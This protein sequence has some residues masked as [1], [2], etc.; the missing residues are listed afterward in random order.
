MNTFNSNDLERISQIN[1]NNRRKYEKRLI[2]KACNKIG[3]MLIICTVVMNV[4]AIPLSTILVF[5]GNFDITGETGVSGIPYSLYYLL[6]GILEF[7]GF[8]LVPVIFCLIFKFKLSEALPIRGEGKYNIL[9]LILGGYAICTLS[10]Y[11]VSILNS[12]LSMFGLENTTGI[13]TEAKTPK[14]QIIYFICIAIIPAITEEIAFRG[15]VL[16][17]LRPYDDGFAVLVSAIL[18]GLVHGNFVQIPF[19]FIV[20]LVCAVLVVKTNSI[21]PSI[22]LHLLNNGTSVLLDCI[23]E[24]TSRGTYEILSTIIVMVLTIIG[25]VAIIL[26]CKKGFD[27]KF[28]NSR[29]IVC[30]KTKEKVTAFMSNPGSIIFVSFYIVYALGVLFGYV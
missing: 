28:Q 8:F 27:M 24:Y 18:F 23:E 17:F 19:A 1:Q 14:E 13:V 3:F 9:L 20:G 10:N 15:V 12:N 11:A 25:F 7:S 16:N 6:N 30:L 22:L 21:I 26:L 2:R 5:T 29:E 4:L